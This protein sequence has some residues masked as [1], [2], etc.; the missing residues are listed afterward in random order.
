MDIRTQYKLMI[1]ITSF[2]KVRTVRL[3]GS[4]RR[5]TCC[6]SVCLPG[7]VSCWMFIHGCFRAR[8]RA[9][10]NALRVGS[11]STVLKYVTHPKDDSRSLSSIAHSSDA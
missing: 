7:M 1:A 4:Y 5:F 3:V 8:A 6:A 10:Q 2:A 11:I 9:A